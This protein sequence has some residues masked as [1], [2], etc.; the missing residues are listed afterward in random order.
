MPSK[1]RIALAS[2]LAIAALG[3]VA[4]AAQSEPYIYWSN[5]DNTIGRAAMSGSNPTQAFISGGSDVKGLA[6][7]SNDLFWAN[8][9]S[10]AIGRSGRNGTGTNQ[11][12]IT[13]GSNTYFVA[14]DSSYVYWSNYGSNTIG[15]ANLDGSVANQ[16]FISGLPSN[17]SGIAVDSQYIYWSAENAG[18]IGRA[19]L[20]G[21]SPNS[22]FITGLNAP[23]GVAV[24]SDYIYWASFGNGAIGRANINGTSPNSSF[25]TGLAGP[26]GVAVNS[27]YIYWSEYF[28]NSVGRANIDGTTPDRSFITAAI[29]PGGL[30]VDQ[31]SGSLT[32][33]TYDFGDIKASGGEKST[34]LTLTSSGNAPLLIQ[35]SSI[36]GDGGSFGILGGTC[37]S[38]GVSLATGESCTASINFAPDSVGSKTATYFLATNAGLKTVSLSGT[39]VPAPSLTP[40]R[41]S[42]T[43]SR[44][45]VGCGDSNSCSLRLTGR[46]VGTNAQITPK[47]V[48]V[49]AGQRPV[50]TLAYSPALKRAFAK[51][52]RLS[53]TATRLNAT[54]AAKTITVTVRR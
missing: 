25:I 13:G 45:K 30:A 46:K 39:G 9:G 14:T 15:R 23:V 40:V 54:G 49:G 37:L 6:L 5:N 35:G 10:G 16:S 24:D 2:I 51:G 32:P 8:F 19:N 44:F 7:S 1:L 52:G 31:A 3:A 47:T 41:T 48:A 50:V 27:P 34:T 26:T 29:G 38:G 22:T 20:D 53:V 28:N 33:A 11:S 4:P 18:T 43:S 42:K 21:T 17:P 12:F 36:G